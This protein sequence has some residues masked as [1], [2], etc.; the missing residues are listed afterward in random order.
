MFHPHTPP[1]FIHLVNFVFSYLFSF[2]E[3]RY[4]Y[5]I[6]DTEE[7]KDLLQMKKWLIFSVKRGNVY[8]YMD[9]NVQFWPA[10]TSVFFLKIACNFY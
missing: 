3:S 5:I 9:G 2:L 1:L 7:S 4:L 8:I 10:S 6:F